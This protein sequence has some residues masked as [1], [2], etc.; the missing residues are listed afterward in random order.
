MQ[1]VDELNNARSLFQQSRD[2][3]LLPFTAFVVLCNWQ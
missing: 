1:S 2:I 3:C